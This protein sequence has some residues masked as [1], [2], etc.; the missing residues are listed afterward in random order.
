MEVK[1][2]KLLANVVHNDLS[3]EY[4]FLKLWNI[5]LDNAKRRAGCCKLNA[6]LITVSRFH[7]EHNPK[8]VVLDTLLHEFAHAVAFTLYKDRGHGKH[9]KTVARKLGANPKSTGNFKLPDAPWY[10]VCCDFENKTFHEVSPRYRR[11]RSLV[12]CSLNGSPNT[13]GNL[14]YLSHSELVLFNNGEK[15]FDSLEFQQ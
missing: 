15:S 8:H 4:E 13:L 11:S 7:I 2:F 9:W 10:I 5:R 6:Q 3:S 12:N 14:Y 1:A